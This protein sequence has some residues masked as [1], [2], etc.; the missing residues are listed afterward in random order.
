MEETNNLPAKKSKNE[1]SLQPVSETE[2]IILIDENEEISS[3]PTDTDTWKVMIVDDDKSI[4]EVTKLALERFRFEGKSLTLISAYSGAAA[5]QLIL[6]NPDTAILLVDIR[7]ETDEA[8]LDLVKYVRETL[9][10]K[11]IRI[12]L[13]TGHS[14]QTP[15]SEIIL[16]YDI[17][18]YK[19]KLELTQEKLVTTVTLSLRNYK[20]LQETLQQ[21]TQPTQGNI[22]IVDDDKNHLKLLFEILE[23]NGYTVRATQ[24][25][26]HALSSANT[27][28]PDLMILDVMMPDLDGY[29]LC[30]HLKANPKTCNIPVVF[31]SALE[32]AID[33]V[34]AFQSG[35]VDFISKPFEIE[36]VL[37]RVEIH[38]NNQKLKQQLHDQNTRL[39][40]EIE[41]RRTTEAYLRLLQ[42]AVAASSNGIV[43]SDAQLDDHP[44]IYVNTGFEKIT[45]YRSDEI[46]GE[47]CRC[48]QGKDT[49]QPGLTE[50]RE[51]IAQGRNANVI[52]RNYRKDGSL[53]WNQLAVSPVHDQQGNLTHFIGIQEDI[54]D[55]ILSEAAQ[56]QAEEE[57]RR[58][59]TLLKETQRIAKVG[60]WSWDLIHNKHWW[61]EQM[62]QLTGIN[63]NNISFNLEQIEQKIHPEDRSKVRQAALNAVKQGE[64]TEIEFRILNSEDNIHYLIARTQVQRNEQ[65]KIIRLY[66]TLQ[67]ISDYKQR[68]EALRLF[69][70]E[71]AS[72][73]G[74]EFFRTCVY[75][76][77]KVL[78]VEY[79]VIAEVLDETPKKMR[80]LAFWSGDHLTKNIEY[81]VAGTPCEPVISQG[82]CYYPNK[83]KEHFSDQLFLVELDVES[84]WGIPLVNSHGETIGLIYIMDRAPLQIDLDQEMI[85]KIFATRTEAELERQ[86]FEIT[87]HHA[88]E[89]AEAASR[90]K[91]TFLANMSHE[92]RTPLN[93]ILGFSQLLSYS[94]NLS[95]DEEENLEVIRSS[96]QHLLTLINQVLDLSKIEAGCMKLQKQTFDLFYLLKTVERMFTP[97]ARDKNLKL[98]FDRHP[99]LSQFIYTDETKLR[100]VLINLLNNAI[101]FT[102]KGQVAVR[103]R[104]QPGNRDTVCFE[105]QDTG[106]GIAPQ[107]CKDLF[108]AFVQTSSGQQSQEGTGLGLKISQQF[109][110]LMGGEITVNSQIGKG[111]TFKFM[112]PVEI[113]ETEIISPS[114]PSLRVISLEPHPSPYRIL[115]VDD[116][117]DNRKLLIELLTPVGFEVKGV[118]DGQ[119]AVEQWLSWQPHLI[120]MDLRMP[121]MDGYAA[122]RQIRH[123]ETALRTNQP[124][125]T[126]S[127]SSEVEKTKIIAISA[128]ILEREESIALSVGCDDFLRKPFLERD[129]FERIAQHLEVRYIFQESTAAS[130]VSGICSTTLTSRDLA[131]LPVEWLA[132]FYQAIIEGRS[133]RMQS[134]IKQIYSQSP[135]LADAL[136]FLVD[137]YQYE[138]LLALMQPQTD[139]SADLR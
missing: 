134:L 51:G 58:S 25:A 121:M 75:Y 124:L 60:G 131:Q 50:L 136:L 84:Y 69:S 42:R 98:K 133:Q 10:N 63:P 102:Q 112:I 39:Q 43:I 127:L 2:D 71:I 8:G 86:Q 116:R 66:G 29:A 111:T 12:I 20:T 3:S 33:K 46:I 89:A 78:Q 62:Y 27:N 52:L 9:K 72:K 123:L 77:A 1:I 96:G 93:A 135:S 97:K 125:Q 37:A 76:L 64:M 41:I 88:K 26:K 59:E 82:S 114:P 11:L 5:K 54:S 103:V 45:G 119:E 110:N 107:E 28:Q 34:Q 87:L 118:N 32:G 53:F 36:E 128:G 132:Q 104:S 49:D 40:Q 126:L 4:H 74:E 94:E 57:L 122:T 73:T 106:V 137:R 100:Q 14:G 85:L 38:L 16:N 113:P 117:S 91:S 56:K 6:Q 68:E 35:A 47:N 67:D 80:T 95:I 81:D 48:L 17:N 22:L 130:K 13:R 83:I 109:V 61:S 70:E 19:T 92:L 99:N 24:N 129:V 30:K 44:V 55:R 139:R 90:A 7:M 105:I 15:A 108:Q 18:D 23:Q 79:T 120:F 31:I 138:Q 115:I 21:E 101:K 65:G